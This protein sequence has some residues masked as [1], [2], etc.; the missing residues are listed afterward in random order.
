MKI[1]NLKDL[2]EVNFPKVIM[3]KWGY[4]SILYNVVK[5]YS[6][7]YRKK[8]GL[9]AAFEFLTFSG[10]CSLQQATHPDLIYDE[11]KGLYI[12]MVSDY[13]YGIEKM[14]NSYIFASRD[15]LHF[16]NVLKNEALDKY[17]GHGISHFSDGEIIRGRDGI[18]AYYRYCERDK[19]DEFSDLIY[20]RSSKNL[21]E[22]TQRELIIRAPRDGF[23]SP[24][25]LFE[26][27]MYKIYYV[28]LT[29]YGSEL[30]FSQSSECKF[31]DYLGHTEKQKVIN[32]PEGW[33]LW[34]INVTRT[35]NGKLHGLFTLSEGGGGRNA[36]L[37]YAGF[38]DGVWQISGK[39][40]IDINMEYVKKI[41]RAAFVETENGLE[42]Y[43]SICLKNDSW[44][45]LREKSFQPF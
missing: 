44:Y 17:W 19:K 12:L 18:Y 21:K 26:E 36:R 27:E 35:R 23:L 29:D 16:H 5:I 7:N 33:M 8:I 3:G 15:G 32:M 20:M 14:E 11:S 37:Y 4:H 42:L 22:W 6:E 28:T 38:K 31:C 41:Y 9:G 2:K 43:V 39:V 34:H 10:G 40:S 1:R 24:S 45:V 13:P 30:Y 25:I